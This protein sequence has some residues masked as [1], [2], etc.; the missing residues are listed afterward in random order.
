VHIGQKQV[1][2]EYFPSDLLQ[3]RAPQQK[4]ASGV[5]LQNSRPRW[6][7]RWQQLGVFV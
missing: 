6:E 7:D 5:C 3:V 1:V 4:F 2:F